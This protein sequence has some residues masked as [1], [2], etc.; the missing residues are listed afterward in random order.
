MYRMP[1]RLAA[2]FVLTLCCACLSY[3][4]TLQDR[5]FSTDRFR[6]HQKF[7]SKFLSKDRDLMVWLPAGYDADTTRRYPVMY[8]HDGANVF[9]DWRIDEVI[10]K[11]VVAK[12]ME[13]L[14]IV[15]IFNG[16]T[17]EDRFTEYTPTR[18]AGGKG[19]K[20]DLYGQ[21]LVEEIKPLIDSEYRTLTDA[22]NTG[23]GG[24]SLGGLVS[25]YLGLK[26]PNV[27]GKLAVMSPSVW[28]DDRVIVRYVKKL[29]AKPD[30][31][32][33]LDIGTEE[34]PTKDVRELRDALLSA[35]WRLDADL[36]YLEAKGA[37]H[38]EKSWAQ[39]SGQVLK[40]L[41]SK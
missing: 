6:M 10:E 13:P 1:S 3:G 31:R 29:K 15:G 14:I 17:D 26:Y 35:G 33:W 25:L 30:V 39:R 11:L 22:A 21:M 7:H 18:I 38:N 34:G 41:F 16:G 8:M 36:M 32:I 9:V 27:F 12:E 5:T 2:I 24:S 20:A 19:G 40:Y 23:M 28:W 37:K 4:S